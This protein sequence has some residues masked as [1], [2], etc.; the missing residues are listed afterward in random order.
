MRRPTEDDLWLLVGYAVWFALIWGLWQVVAR[1][2][3]AD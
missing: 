3:P 2:R 1:V